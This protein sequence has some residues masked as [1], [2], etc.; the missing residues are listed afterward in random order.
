MR[1]ARLASFALALVAMVATAAHAGWTQGEFLSDGK[2]VEENHCSPAGPGPFPAVILLHG[3]GPRDA[4]KQDFEEFCTKLADQGYYAEFIE[5][6]SQPEPAS[7]GDVAGMMR[8][9]PTWM[10]EI[11]SGFAALKKNSAVDSKKVGMMGFSL[12]AFLSL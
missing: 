9:F 1:L 8:D 10:R 5:Y 12:G 11:N 6:Y 2:P 3:A 7:A 4:G